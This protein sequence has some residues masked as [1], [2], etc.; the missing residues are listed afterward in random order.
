LQ[1]CVEG[2][3][4]FMLCCPCPLRDFDANLYLCEEAFGLLPFSTFQRLSDTLL[5]YAYVFVLLVTVTAAFV[6]A[7]QNLRYGQIQKL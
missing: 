4:A 6:V 7:F 2:G 3:L 1:I 5:F